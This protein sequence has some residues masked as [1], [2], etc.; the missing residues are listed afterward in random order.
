MGVSL[1]VYRAA[2]GLF[3]DCSLI[4]CI[5]FSSLIFYLYYS[6]ISVIGFTFSSLGGDNEPHNP[7]SNPGSSFLRGHANV[8]GLNIADKFDELVSII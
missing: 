1:E 7:E 8:R 2:I 5:C 6:H 4:K 3:N